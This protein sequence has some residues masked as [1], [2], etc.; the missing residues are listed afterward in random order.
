MV[1]VLP[2]IHQFFDHQTLD[3]LV[4]S[5]F[6]IY[7]KTSDPGFRNKAMKS[8]AY[9]CPS[10]RPASVHK[11]VSRMKEQIFSTSE[12]TETAAL[13]ES[14]TMIVK[15]TK[16]EILEVYKILASV[17]QFIVHPNN[18]VMQKALLFIKLVYEESEYDDIVKIVSPILLGF[19]E[20]SLDHQEQESL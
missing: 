9:I 6:Q 1:R 8:I 11:I 16:V 15:N 2:E 3:E 14:L 7:S 12:F 13:I 5:T 20:V 19:T 18:L 17:K 4:N 10:L